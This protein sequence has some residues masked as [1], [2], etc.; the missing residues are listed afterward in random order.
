MEVRSSPYDVISKGLA[1]GEVFN[2]KQEEARAA[3]HN[4]T[5]W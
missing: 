2:V 5:Y 1:T 4:K 3:V